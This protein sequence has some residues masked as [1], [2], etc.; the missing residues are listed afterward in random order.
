MTERMLR[1]HAS[2]HPVRGGVKHSSVGVTQPPLS[3]VLA[4]A[5]FNLATLH[6]L[7]NQNTAA[8]AEFKALLAAAPTDYAKVRPCEESEGCTG[9]AAYNGEERS[10]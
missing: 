5:A 2:Q 3:D 9:N 8:V 7:Q 10:E 4:D 1:S 6:Y